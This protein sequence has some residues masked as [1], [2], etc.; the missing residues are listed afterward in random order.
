ME[1]TEEPEFLDKKGNPI[2]KGYY[3]RKNEVF[4]FGNNTYSQVGLSPHSLCWL[5]YKTPKDED[6]P[7]KPIKV[8]RSAAQEFVR[9]SRD[10][11]LRVIKRM[12]RDSSRK[13]ARAKEL[14]R[15]AGELSE[16]SERARYASGDL[17]DFLERN[18]GYR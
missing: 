8:T 2:D 14:K 11:L 9:L 7:T 10:G 6:L 5:A 17:T 18:P 3:Q 12:K 16:E 13:E 15:K 1:G 4:Y